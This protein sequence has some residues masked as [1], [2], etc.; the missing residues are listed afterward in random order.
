MN[1]LKEALKF[2]LVIFSAVIASAGMVILVNA[3]LSL[4]PPNTDYL[5]RIWIGIILVA[6]G[7]IL[8]ML[9]GR[10]ISL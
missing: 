7:S 3:F 4:L 9:V 5:F 6:I 1:G 8:G 10:K 2:F